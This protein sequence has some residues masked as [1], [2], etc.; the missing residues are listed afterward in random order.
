MTVIVEI[1]SGSSPSLMCDTSI[2][3]K[4]TKI[5]FFDIMAWLEGNFIPPIRTLGL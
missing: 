4:G 1:L 2:D 5:M 3:D